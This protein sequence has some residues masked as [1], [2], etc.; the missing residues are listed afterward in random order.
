MRDP[1]P[2]TEEL[3]QARHALDQAER[4]LEAARRRLAH[5]RDAVEAL[6]EAEDPEGKS[7]GAH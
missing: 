2:A 7:W 3:R 6:A 4:D 1:P 5:A